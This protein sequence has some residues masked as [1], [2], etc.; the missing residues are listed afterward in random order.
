MVKAAAN[1]SILRDI[2]AYD[3]G[4]HPF[5]RPN[6][7]QDVFDEQGKHGLLHA[8]FQDGYIVGYS[9]TRKFGQPSDPP[10]ANFSLP[11]LYADNLQAAVALLTGI[12][13]NLTSFT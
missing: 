9:S 3:R 5:P 10:P 13:V 1:D 4:I 6:F 8:A 11:M 12:Q 2:Q 7:L